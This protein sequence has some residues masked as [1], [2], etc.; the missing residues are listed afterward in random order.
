MLLKLIR[1]QA[2][3]EVG[4]QGKEVPFGSELNWKNEF[5]VLDFSEYH[6]DFA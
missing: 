2:R 6:N 1:Q 4:E 3:F 5:E